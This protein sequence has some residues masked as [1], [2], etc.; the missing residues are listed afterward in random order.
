VNLAHFEEIR[1]RIQ[2]NKLSDSANNFFTAPFTPLSGRSFSR[3]VSSQ[4]LGNLK[5]DNQEHVMRMQI[6]ILS[7]Q[8]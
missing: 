3:K 7:R 4:Y 5:N 2:L 1:G 8:Y 6:E